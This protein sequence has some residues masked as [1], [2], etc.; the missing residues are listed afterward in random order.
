MTIRDYAERHGLTLY[1]AFYKAFEQVNPS[2]SRIRVAGDVAIY[3][4]GGD[5]PK[6]VSDWLRF[7]ERTSTEHLV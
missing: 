1:E 5:P 4:H 7:H 2:D 3:K 6:Y